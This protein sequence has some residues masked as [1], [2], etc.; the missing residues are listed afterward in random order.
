MKSSIDGRPWS[1]WVCSSRKSLDGIRRVAECG[2]GYE[3]ENPTCPYLKSYKHRNQVQFKSVPPQVVCS[4]CG[5]SAKKVNCTARK[6]WE[7]PNNVNYVLVYHYGTHSCTAIK[8]ALDVS[9]EVRKFFTENTSAKP[10][11]C[12]YESLKSTFNENKD[13]EEV[14]KKAEGFVNYK[15]LQNVKQNVLETINP[16]GHSFDAVATIKQSADKVDKYLIYGAEDGRISKNQVGT[17]VF[18]TSLE[19]VEMM[20]QMQFETDGVLS[21]QHCFLDAEHD[22]VH[23]FKTI[24][25]SVE[26]PTLKELV[27]LA[28]MDCVGENT[29]TL[30]EF[31]SQVNSVS[32]EI[33]LFQS[34]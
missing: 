13:V 29:D 22:R 32:F 3:C 7:F 20:Y 16:L 33:Y 5:Y 24:N 6:I 14:Y 15:K 8:P 23:K 11:Q 10:S 31:W 34:Q 4:C 26:H 12:A 30:C 21:Q 1:R 27:T 18:R 2:G 28:S 19:K 25:L 17:Y 9:G